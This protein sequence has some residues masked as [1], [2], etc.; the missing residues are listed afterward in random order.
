M[1][2]D[3]DPSWFALRRVVFAYGCRL[4]MS[5]T[6][7]FTEAYAAS[8]PLFESAL[9][10]YSDLMFTR[11]SLVSVQAVILMAHFAEGLGS[12]TLQYNLGSSALHLACSKG[13]HRQP[14]PSW[15]LLSG[16][17]LH[18]S[19]I[20][21][22]IYCFETSIVARTGRPAGI[23][24]D[25]ITCLV[26]DASLGPGASHSLYPMFMTK[27]HRFFSMV[28]KRLS[29][30]RAHGQTQEQLAKTVG[31]LDE[32]LQGLKK[33]L[34]LHLDLDKPVDTSDLDST[35]TLNQTLAL[36]FTYYHL[37]LHLHFPMACPWSW[38]GT[39]NPSTSFLEQ[40]TKSSIAVATASR[41]TIMSTRLLSVD[42]NS[43]MA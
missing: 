40:A 9:S 16:D 21:W 11:I 42:V 3:D 29:K 43:P 10:A 20:F 7:T 13:L 12:I 34:S 23:D 18:R 25:E 2:T 38:T 17:V 15:G 14:A 19:R 39:Q 1:G 35:L 30:V 5:K 6:H 26:P 8:W 22:A 4:K 41:A 32:E 27:L 33:S 24:D 31:E 37:V 36:H 28:S